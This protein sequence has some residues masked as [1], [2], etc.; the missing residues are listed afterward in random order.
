MN[1]K[2]DLKRTEKAS[3]RLAAY[4]DGTSDLALGLTFLLLGLYPLTRAAFGPDWN[5][6]FFLAVLG[7]IVGLQ[8]WVRYRLGPSRLGI[9]EF[10]PRV[11]NR[12]RLALVITILLAG[13]MIATWVL[14]ARGW[15]PGTPGWLG[16]YG[17][18]IIVSLIVLAIMWGMAYT[19]ELTRYYFYGLL[20]AAGFL[21]QAALPIYEG[22]PFLAAGGIIAIIGAVLLIRFLQKYPP[23]D[24]EEKR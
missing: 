22:L 19:L 23:L 15:F 20:L 16:A 6:L 5:M 13:A 24:P 1:A 10:G 12:L 8:F 17:F 9:V 11:K 4:G 7:S 3:Y 18:E 21:L 2:L 14:S